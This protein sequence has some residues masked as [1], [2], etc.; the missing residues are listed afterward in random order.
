[1]VVETHAID[2]TPIAYTAKPFLHLDVTYDTGTQIN[3]TNTA[4]GN[5]AI[6]KRNIGRHYG[7]FLL[8]MMAAARPPHKH[9]Q[10][11]RSLLVVDFHMIEIEGST[12]D[13]A[14]IQSSET[15]H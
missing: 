7:V 2:I 6:Y 5:S 1:M 3:Q 13:P 12:M 11:L 8:K 15:G 14:W 9:T 10:A 4:N